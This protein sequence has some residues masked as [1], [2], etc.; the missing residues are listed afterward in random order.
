MPGKTIV[1]ADL[2]RHLCQGEFAGFVLLHYLLLPSLDVFA[3]AD[4]GNVVCRLKL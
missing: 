3:K 2:I 1:F 4:D